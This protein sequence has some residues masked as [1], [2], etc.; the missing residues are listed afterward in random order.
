M[1]IS[2]KQSI[3]LVK[4]IYFIEYFFCI[5]FDIIHVLVFV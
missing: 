4:Q 3:Q 2:R 1:K 5:G